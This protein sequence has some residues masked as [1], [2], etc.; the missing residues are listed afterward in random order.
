MQVE[1]KTHGVPCALVFVRIVP[2]RIRQAIADVLPAVQA[3]LRQSIAEALVLAHDVEVPQE[4]RGG[5]AE[6]LLVFRRERRPR[7]ARR[8][9]RDGSRA[10]GGD[11]QELEIRL[12]TETGQACGVRSLPM[13]AQTEGIP[14]LSLAMHV[15]Q[16]RVAGHSL[17]LDR[18]QRRKQLLRQP[19]EDVV[20]RDHVD[21]SHG[22]AD[23]A[24]RIEIVVAELLV[25]EVLEGADGAD[26]E[27]Q[28]ALG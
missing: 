11:S 5:L 27:E 20:L 3:V 28:A 10:S 25:A 1:I 12:S 21:L 6:V 2:F 16:L 4:P 22:V 15:Q 26:A 23:E 14:P 9:L 24:H 13:H 18:E 7:P 19:S 17:L 8:Q